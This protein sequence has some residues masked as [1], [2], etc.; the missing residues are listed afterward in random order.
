MK[1]WKRKGMRRRAAIKAK[2]VLMETRISPE[3]AYKCGER[4]YR[5]HEYKKAFEYFRYAAGQGVSKA[6]GKMA[7]MYFRGLGC[8]VDRDN[9][10][11]CIKAA[12]ITAQL[13]ESE[14]ASQNA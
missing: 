5:R 3:T 10:H 8:N 13:E 4:H 11:I 6:W 2:K 1:F 7:V 14:M 9:V 12:R